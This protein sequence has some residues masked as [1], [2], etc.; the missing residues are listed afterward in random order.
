[1][2][3]NPF[4]IVNVTLCAELRLV[5]LK[6]LHQTAGVLQQKMSVESFFAV[7]VQL[8]YDIVLHE[9]VVQKV[10]RIQLFVRAYNNLAC[11]P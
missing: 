4:H 6:Q 3:Q 1:M 7:G 8:V 9:L 2:L 11:R 10:E 5:L